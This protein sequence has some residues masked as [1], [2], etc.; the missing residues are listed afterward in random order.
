MLLDELARNLRKAELKNLN[1]SQVPEGIVKSFLF[2]SGYYS[3]FRLTDTFGENACGFASSVSQFSVRQQQALVSAGAKIP[4][5]PVEISPP[6]DVL[7]RNPLHTE[8]VPRLVKG[9]RRARTKR[10]ATARDEHP[11]DQ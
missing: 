4:I 7:H 2:S 1:F 3:A 8:E 6:P 11:G 9:E 10:T 5:V